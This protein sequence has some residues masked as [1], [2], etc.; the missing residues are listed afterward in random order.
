MGKL[1]SL[2]SPIQSVTPKAA[3]QAAQTARRSV[4]WYNTTRW[5][6]LR[7]EVLK[8]DGYVCQAT[9][10]ALVGRHP[11]DN[12]PVVDHIRPHRGDPDL[13]W[14]PRNLRAVAKSWHDREKQSLE[15]RGQA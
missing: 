13:F 11:A 2:G 6:R 9:G 14:D 5:R 4:S 7:A 15:K 1:R 10:V 3:A 8:R 12:A